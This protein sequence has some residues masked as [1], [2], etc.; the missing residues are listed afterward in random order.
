VCAVSVAVLVAACLMED[1]QKVSA[2]CVNM[3]KGVPTGKCWV[4]LIFFSSYYDCLS[5][6]QQAGRLPASGAVAT[7]HPTSTVIAVSTAYGALMAGCVCFAVCCSLFSL[8]TSLLGCMPGTRV[9]TGLSRS[10]Y[11]T[12]S[13]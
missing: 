4:F 9:R 11:L 2:A 6:A 12:T 13:A 1:R 7:S 10:P 5:I 3:Q 8:S